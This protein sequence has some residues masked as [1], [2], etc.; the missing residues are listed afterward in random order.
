MTSNR[1]TLPANRI[2]QRG[3]SLYGAPVDFRVEGPTEMTGE[4]ERF[5]ANHAWFDAHLT[6]LLKTQRGRFVAID[7]GAVL[8]DAQEIQELARR[9]GKDAGILIEKVA[10]PEDESLYMY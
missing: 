6:E 2:I 1:A 7:G 4:R 10:R 8:G 9:F 5:A 3:P